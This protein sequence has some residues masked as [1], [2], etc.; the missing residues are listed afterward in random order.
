MEFVSR[1]S[2]Y[3]RMVILGQISDRGDAIDVHTIRDVIVEQTR[4]P[5]CGERLFRWLVKTALRGDAIVPMDD[6]T[7]Y[8]DLRLRDVPEFFLVSLSVALSSVTKTT[9]W[10]STVSPAERRMYLS[11]NVSREHPELPFLTSNLALLEFTLNRVDVV[12]LF[13]S[14]CLEIRTEF[15]NAYEHKRSD[16][17]TGG[18]IRLIL[19]P[20][21]MYQIVD[22][23]YGGVLHS[24]AQ[25]PETVASLLVAG[26]AAYVTTTTH[27][28]S[29]HYQSG[30]V[31]AMHSHRL[32]PLNHPVR[33]VLLPTELGTTS[34]LGRALMS[35]VGVRGL[36]AQAFGYTFAGGLKPMVAAYR[37]WDPLQ[38]TD[39]R[40]E[41]IVGGPHAVRDECLAVVQRDYRRWWRYIHQ[42][43]T[44]I[45]AAL[46]PTE[47]SLC[48]DQILTTWLSAVVGTTT[49]GSHTRERLIVTMS[50]PFFD[51]LRHNHLSSVPMSH[52]VRYAGI[53]N[54]YDAP[55]SNVVHLL[56]TLEA[57]ANI[58]WLPLVGRGFGDY[59]GSS[60][61]PELQAFYKGLEPMGTFARSI[62]TADALPSTIEASCGY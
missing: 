8:E 59:F 37:G 57:V 43:M 11:D 17:L 32:L 45:V 55:R 25:L 18:T 22:V 58:P 20:D 62:E 60:S 14:E 56:S 9:F 52:I 13:H 53:L 30:H 6:A 39:P 28:L 31:R 51:L 44:D 2:T 19:L 49:T 10:T 35:L 54:P 16:R 3:A 40:T 38:L 5:R 29:Q 24:R 1:V 27:L 15:L 42:H 33:G 46:Y 36:F 48:A 41:L 23:L 50:L 7:M 12:D 61:F 4:A 21:G 26:I 47:A 34:A